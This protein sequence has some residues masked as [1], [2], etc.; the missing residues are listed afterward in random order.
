MG[1]LLTLLVIGVLGAGIYWVVAK[2]FSGG[3]GESSTVPS[4]TVKLMTLRDKVV[5]QGILESQSTING[6]CEIDHHENKIIFLAP[7]GSHVKKGQVV[8]KFDSSQFEEYVSERETRVNDSKAEVESAQQ[9]LI[10][11]QDENDTSIR[12]AKQEL[13]FA[14]LDLE[15]YV[16]GDYEVKLSDIKFAISESKTKLDKER[17]N[18]ESMRALVKRGFREFE[19]LRESEQVVR[20]AEIALKRDEQ[21]LETLNKF[22]HVKSLAEFEGKAKEAKHKFEVAKT[23]ADAKLNQAKD[24]LKNEEMGLKIQGR[25]LKQLKED[26]AKHTMLA[27]Q[28]G[29]LAYSSDDWRGNGEKL[30]AGSVIYQNQP[31]FVLPDMSRMQVKVG[32][33]ESLVSKVKPGQKAIIRADA[34]SSVALTGTVKSVSP[35]SASTRWQ[36]SNNYT[37]IVTID[38]LPG[39]IKLKPGM[40]AAT[41]ILVGQYTDVIGVPIQA[42]ASFG[43]KKFVFVQNGNEFEPREVEVGNSNVSF[44]EV[45]SGVSE[46][47]VVALDAYQRALTEFSDQ[48]PDDGDDESDRLMAEL[49]PESEGAEVGQTSNEAADADLPPR[50]RV[51]DDPN[52]DDPNSDKPPKPRSNEDP[53]TSQDDETSQGDETKEGDE[54]KVGDETKSSDFNAIELESADVSS[55]AISA[56]GSVIQLAPK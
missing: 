25:R 16:N 55:P 49:L 15:K 52:S 20:S 35:L 33:H 17:R 24:K 51:E 32:V 6:T 54:T 48:E 37:V 53:E 41:E 4:T 1:R 19:Q 56:P 18:M 22:E 44:V 12:A 26:L 34:F 46:G 36:P 21:K 31:V 14:E 8:C 9:A 7:E 43:R 42:V 3:G 50:P 47:E 28:D 2:S 27:P 39:D 11:Q 5:E 38:K 30:H 13:E 45:E 40:N 29:T 23:T 10:V